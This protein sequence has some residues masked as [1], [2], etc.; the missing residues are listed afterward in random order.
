MILTYTAAEGDV[1][2]FHFQ[3]KTLGNDQAEDMEDVTGKNFVELQDL[4][5]A[6]NMRA[7]R[8][9]LWVLMKKQHPMLKFADLQ[10]PVGAV[11][12][13]ME[14]DELLEARAA[15]AELLTSKPSTPEIDAAINQMDESIAAL[16]A[17]G[18]TP[19]GEVSEPSND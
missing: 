15:V 8:A 7:R 17:A 3:F 16:Q 10:Y 11:S 9:L 5:G 19:K 2:T 6:G 13:D 1:Q 4:V 18:V 12:I 14:L